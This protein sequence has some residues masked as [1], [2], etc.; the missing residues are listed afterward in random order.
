ME[1]TVTA[2][3]QG[4][5]SPAEDGGNDHMTGVLKLQES[6]LSDKLYTHAENE[7]AK[8]HESF[9]IRVTRKMRMWLIGT[10]ENGTT[11]GRNCI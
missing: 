2:L 8:M 9:P 7:E 11:S 5:I 1:A 4:N 3:A 6:R 10:N